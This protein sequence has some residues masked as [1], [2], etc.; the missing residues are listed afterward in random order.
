MVR[1]GDTYI[2][3]VWKL[4]GLPGLILKARDSKSHYIYQPISIR[5]ENAGDVEYYDY[6]VDFRL[7]MKNRKKGL[8]RK[9]KHLH[10]DIHYKIVSSGMFGINNPNVKKRDKN[11]TQTT[12]S[13]RPTTLNQSWNDKRIFETSSLSFSVENPSRL[14]KGG[15]AKQ[16]Q[17][18]DYPH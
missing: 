8:Q 3:R 15:Q 13:R 12:I 5:T 2:R 7:T 4:C 14:S 17:Q 18:T 6:Q 10:T 11:R 1:P 9:F 16:E